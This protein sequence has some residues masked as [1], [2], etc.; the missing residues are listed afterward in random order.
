MKRTELRKLIKEEI[1]AIM[2]EDVHR[3]QE[4][5]NISDNSDRFI[6]DVRSNMI[7]IT[8]RDLRDIKEFIYNTEKDDIIKKID[9]IK[10]DLIKA[11]E[12]LNY[13]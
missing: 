9:E 11:K 5:L 10:N 12:Y 3:H 13:H 6:S 4:N 7:S 2:K 8:G 1:K